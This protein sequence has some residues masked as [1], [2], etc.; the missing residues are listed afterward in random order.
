MT[1]IRILATALA[2][3]ASASAFAQSTTFANGNFSSGLNGWTSAGDVSIL[4]TRQVAALTTASVDYDDDAPLPA[5][6]NNRSGV[7]AVDF[8]FGGADFLGVSFAALDAASGAG[9]FGT[10]EGSGIRQNFYANAGD[11][12]TIRFDWAFLSADT[13]NADFGFVAVNGSVVKFVDAFSAPRVS[14]FTGTFGDM[15]NASWGWTT[16]DY[17]YT[18]TSSG[19]VSLVLG[20]VDVKSYAGTSELRVD[21]ITVTASPVPEPGAWALSLAGL[22]VAASVARRRR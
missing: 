14:Q 2:L 6:F 3:S 1:S 4:G 10:W 11:T 13:D 9:A 15:N 8:A 18:A 22:L 21:N 7:A 19:L 16:A 12:L 5:G 20:V 17:T